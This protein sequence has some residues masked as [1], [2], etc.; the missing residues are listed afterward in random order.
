MKIALLSVFHPYRGG[1]AQFNASLFKSLQ[2]NHEVKVFTFTRQYPDFLF[3]GT[4]QYVPEADQDPKL[5]SE[6]VLDSVNPISYHRTAK[7]IIAYSPDLLLIS[8]W[9]PFFAPSFGY[10]AGKL[11]KKGCKVVGLLHNI[12]PHEKRPGDTALNKY[13]LNRC[14]RFVVLSKSVRDDLLTLKPNAD[15]VL[16][17]HPVYDHYGKKIKKSE[18]RQKMGLPQ[19]KK[20]L[21]FFGLIRPYKGLDILM[22]AFKNLPEDFFLLVGGEPYEDREQYE[23]LAESYVNRASLNFRF[24]SDEEVPLFFSAADVSVL[25][26]RTATQSGVVSVAFHFDLP[27]IVTDVGGLRET[28]EAFE[29]GLTAETPDEEAVRKTILSFFEKEDRF[30]SNLDRF[31]TEFSWENLANLIADDKS[32]D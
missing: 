4:S 11:Q 25:P 30:K 8:Y 28:V 9:M 18:A 23:K 13:F 27:V 26:Y 20:I 17:P 19:D 1:I 15:V 22:K 31:K 16:H 2:K 5:S 14:D 7:K 3:P 29:G 32:S 6:R 21:L 12:I 10:V 24:I